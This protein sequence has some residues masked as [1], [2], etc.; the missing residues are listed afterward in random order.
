MI[1]VDVYEDTT[2]SG[3]ETPRV[4][5]TD[6]IPAKPLSVEDAIAQLQINNS[7]FLVF[8]NSANDSISVG[9]QTARRELRA[10]RAGGMT[11]MRVATILAEDSIVLD[12]PGPRQRIDAATLK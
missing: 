11:W 5:E 4:I 7:E 10:D 12:L 1:P 2:E 8:H 3:A 9:V 6:N